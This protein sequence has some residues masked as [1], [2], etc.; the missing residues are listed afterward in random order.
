M[1]KNIPLT[2][3]SLVLF[4]LSSGLFAQTVLRY[5]THGFTTNVRNDMHITDAMKPGNTGKNTLWNFSHM[6]INQDFSGSFED[7]ASFKDASRFH[8][9][10]TVVEEFGN[11]FY[12][13]SDKNK[14]EQYGYVTREGNVIEYHT[15]FVKMQY[16]FAYGDAFSGK[17]DATLFVND[18]A[19]GPIDGTY[20]VVADAEGTLVLPG[21]IRYENALRVKEVKLSTQQINGEAYSVENIAYRWFVPQ[22]RFPVLSIISNKWTHPDGGEQAHSLAAYNP[23]AIYHATNIADHVQGK[24]SYSVYPNP[25][26]DFVSI[27]LFVDDA[28]DVNISIFDQNGRL[29][30]ELENLLNHQGELVHTF[31]AA[32]MGLGAGVYYVRFTVNGETKTQRIVEI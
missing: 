27:R 21:N 23:V 17:F 18:E 3:L 29:V 22:H 8:Q 32:Q 13:K 11:L 2:I 9:A 16:P 26:R 28:S 24:I 19:A 15:P 31:S 14:T 10:N 7:P 5:E 20:S 12:F 4:L 30:R 25:Y 1:N 6:K